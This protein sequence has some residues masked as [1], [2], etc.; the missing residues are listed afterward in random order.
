MQVRLSRFLPLKTTE[1]LNKYLKKNNMTNNSNYIMP[2]RKMH[3]KTATPISNSLMI[4]ESRIDSK[5]NNMSQISN[6]SYLEQTQKLQTP[7]SGYS[8]KLKV[9]DSKKSDMT[10]R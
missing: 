5:L 8:R 6:R 4:S 2:K 1:C 3:K 7:K 9:I 10:S